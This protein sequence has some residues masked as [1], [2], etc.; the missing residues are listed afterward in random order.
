MLKVAVTLLL[1]S[2]VP[3]A[4]QEISLEA[5]SNSAQAQA[6]ASLMSSLRTIIPSVVKFSGRLRSS[7]PQPTLPVD[8][9]F[10]LYKDESGGVPIWSETQSLT[11]D[12]QGRFTVFL[13]NSSGGLPTDVFASGEARWL[14]IAPSSGTE[15]TRILFA[16]VPYAF[17]AGDAHTIGGRTADEFVT[18]QQLGSYAVQPV[19]PAPRR[20]GHW[21]PISYQANTFEALSGSGPSFTSDASTGPP[22]KVLSNALV[23]NLNVDLLH[24]FADT[25]FAKLE[26]SNQF[27]SGQQFNGGVVFPPIPG[28]GSDPQSSSDEDFQAMG[29]SNG[30]LTSQVFRWQANGFGQNLAQ[31]QLSFLFG[32]G[33]QTPQPT[34]FSLNSD[35]TFNFAPAQTF[36]AQAIMTAITP[37]LPAYLNPGAPGQGSVA[38]APTGTQTI[39]Q[40]P[41]TSLNVNTINNVRTVQ[42]SDNWLVANNST[43][44]TAGVQ[45]TITLTPCPVGVDVSGSPSLGGPNGGYPVRITDGALPNTNSETVYVKGGT[46]SSA[47]PSGT[48][49]FTPYF[50]H[51]IANYTV[52]SASHGIQEAINDACGTSSTTYKNDACQVTIPPSGPAGGSYPGYD[53]YDTIYF[54]SNGSMLSGYG[55]I[56]NCHERG[57]CLQIGDLIDAN[58]YANDSING[59]S[60]RSP[61]NRHSDPAFNGSLIQSTQRTAGTITITTAAP[62]DLRTGDRVTQMLTDTVNYWGD[63]PAIVVLDPTHYTYTRGNTPDLATQ[64][65]PGVV[66]LAYEAI[67]DNGNSTSFVDIQYDNTYEYGAFNHFFD[68]WDDENAQI[69]KFNNNGISLNENSNWTGSFLWSGGALNLPVTTQQLAPVITV[70]NATITANG[71]NCATVYNSNG[72]FFNNS[73]CQAQGPWEFLVSNTT[74]NYQGAGFQNIYSEASLAVNPTSPA[75]SPWPGLGVSGLIAGPTSGA[76]TFTLSGQGSFA[77]IL[78]TVGTGSTTYVY[79]V[80]ARDLTKGT[81]TSPLPVMYEQEN[82][83]GSVLVQ[84]PRL[85]SGTDTILYDLIRNFAPNGGMGA[86]AGAYV[87]PYNGGCGGGGIQVCGSVAIA[88]PQCS[89]FVCSFADNTANVTS[90]YKINQAD[91]MPN[92]TFWPGTAVLTSTALQS[93]GEVPV[94]GIAFNGAPSEYANTCSGYGTNVSGGYTVCSGSPTPAGNSVPD[95]PPLMLTDGPASGGGG[96]PGAKGRL[97]FESTTTSNPGHHQIITLYDSNPGKT[98]STTGHR[99]VGDPGDMYLGIDPNSNM[100]IGGGVDGIVQYV[101]NIGD[102]KNWGERLTPSLKT[103]S[104]PVQAPSVNVTNGFQINGS[105]G[106]PGQCVIST[107]SGSAWGNPGSSSSAISGEVNTSRSSPKITL[108]AAATSNTYPVVASAES[109]SDFS[110]PEIASSKPYSGDH[111]ETCAKGETCGAVNQVGSGGRPISVTISVPVSFAAIANGNCRDAILPWDGMTPLQGIVPVWPPELKPGL[112]GT[113]FSPSAGALT[114]RMCNFSGVAVTPGELAVAATSVPASMSG[115]ASLRFPEIGKGACEVQAFSMFGATSAKPLIPVWPSTLEDGIL[116]IMRVSAEN[117]VEVRLCNFSGAART[118]ATQIYGAL[119]AK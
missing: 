93:V 96:V 49:V 81:Q 106:Q 100:M 1:V 38:Q 85:S 87:G 65:T 78:P 22:L 51:G 119:I 115:R 4:A 117:T 9:T 79:Y 86:A 98:Q 3:I 52:G 114:V 97:I 46:C 95:Q 72:F 90:G 7:Q 70:S 62:H 118:P 21:I 17:E 47:A 107:G 101:N 50:S 44:L 30:V 2:L 13:G 20:P 80:V 26:A 74:G 16:S 35:G 54:H 91:F 15:G 88:L 89:G 53:V 75:K 77:G 55:A 83:P 69:L 71:S 33:G 27:S 105:Y 32:S 92:P 28:N 109:I 110:P 94:T 63:V 99:P 12:P 66:A 18:K 112:I 40:P 56:L 59:I 68:F 19:G 102:G 67:L 37:L 45:A 41:G 14:G 113:M 39:T 6:N 29:S 60:F 31:S 23:P 34:G 36:P 24:G 25:D 108:N 103:F 57:P 58:D 5:Q 61:D 11:L 43:A 8:V 82:S 111:S 76:G 42:A 64:Q 10:A 73:T 104:V 116:G 84:W 48:V